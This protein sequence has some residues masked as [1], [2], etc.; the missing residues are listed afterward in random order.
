M[1]ENRCWQ[2]MHPIDITEV[3]RR[4]PHGAWAAFI[5]EMELR[6]EQTPPTEALPIVF[7]TLKDIKGAE[8]VI[9]ARN[10]HAG[11]EQW[12]ISRKHNG[13]GFTLYIWHEASNPGT[14]ISGV[15]GVN[16]RKK[17]GGWHQGQSQD[18]IQRD[19]EGK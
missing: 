3:P 16:G 14:P 18:V 15:P 10:K 13:D 7:G 17:R 8:K 6:M 12:G 2:V 11:Q 4:N 9:K 5:A 1:D 19:L